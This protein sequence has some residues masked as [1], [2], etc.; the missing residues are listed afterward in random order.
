MIYLARDQ[1]DGFGAH[2]QQYMWSIVYGESHGHTVYISY[3]TYFEHNYDG[4]EDFTERLIKYMNLH[5]YY[6]LPAELKDKSIPIICSDWSHYNFCERNINNIKNN[7]S[8]KRLKHRFM[9]NKTSPYDSNYYNVALHVRR[10]NSH[11]SRIEGADTP[12]SYY[13]NLMKKIRKEYTAQ[14]PLKFHIYSQGNVSN[15]NKYIGSDTEFHLDDTIENTM[16]GFLFSDIL[17][18]SVSSMS[19]VAALF[20][21]GIVYYK[22]FWHPPINTWNIFNNIPSNN[23]ME[24]YIDSTDIP[25][26]IKH[27]KIDIGL[28]YSAPQSQVWLNHDQDTFV[29]GFEPNPECIETISRGDICKKNPGHGECLSNENAKRFKLIPVALD[30]VSEKK[31]M[32]FYTMAN[33]CGT[34][35][36]NQPIDYGLGPVKNIVKVPVYAL[37]S[38]FDHFPW[39]RFEYIEYVKIDAQ[40]SDLNIVKSAGKYL[41]D[42]IVFVTLEPESRSYANCNHNSTNNII[43]YMTTNGFERYFSPNTDDPTFLNTKFK[44]LANSI[45]IYQKG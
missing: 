40:G 23:D 41:Q 2:L 13:L 5:K 11:D 44:H 20:S 1:K 45:F 31:E 33:D 16:D 24:K 34:S 10:P 25:L 26:N 37:A 27:I 17:I 42:R 30:N 22:P 29:F 8:F 36:L 19:Y 43:E 28:S 7:E 14:K 15:F 12:D 21:D 9:E 35:S 6:G 3:D 32:D 4:S 18:T 39:H 38:F